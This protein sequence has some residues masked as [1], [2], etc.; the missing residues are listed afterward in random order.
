[1]TELPAPYEPIRG[2]HP[3]LDVYGSHPWVMPEGWRRYTENRIADV[4]ADAARTGLTAGARE[5]H[6]MYRRDAP[7]AAW[8]V[9]L[10]WRMLPSAAPIWAGTN[11]D[12]GLELAQPWLDPDNAEARVS[13]DSPRLYRWET[14]CWPLAFFR[15]TAFSGSPS[16]RVA[17][18]EQTREILAIY[19]EVPMLRQRGDALVTLF[20]HVRGDP[21]LLRRHERETPFAIERL[22]GELA[23]P[24]YRALLPELGG[25]V[26]DL[27]WAVEGFDAVHERVTAGADWIDADRVI[28]TIAVIDELGPLAGRS[29]IALALGTD[30]VARIERIRAELADGFERDAWWRES[31]AW[32]RENVLRGEIDAARVWAWLTWYVEAAIGRICGGTI[33]RLL[34][35][36]PEREALDLLAATPVAAPNRVVSWLSGLPAPGPRPEAAAEGD[37]EDE[38]IAPGAGFAPAAPVEI[39]D[40]MAELDALIGLDEVK[41]QV[42]LLVAEQ[43]AAELRREVG[44]DVAPRARHMVFTGSP[45]TAKTTVARLIARI[46]AQLGY[47]EKGHLVETS[48]AGLVAKWIGHTAI[49]TEETFRRALGGVL[50]ID[51]A[52]AL[53]PED[54]GRD[55]GPEAIST[56]LK[57]MEDHRDDVI[58]VVAGYPDE[59]RRFLDSNPGLASRF[60]T[61]IAFPGYDA[62]E[63]VRIFELQAGHAGFRLAPGVTD[64]VRALI[65][66]ERRRDFGNGR[67]VRNVFEAATATQALRITG[68]LTADGPDPTED[69]IRTLLPEDV[70]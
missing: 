51:E 63:L 14:L 64:R 30:R 34:Q 3:Y 28:A 70:G 48:R 17:A 22:W 32:R 54:P 27:A 33:R 44:M 7:A 55:T 50:F 60:P 59:M 46:F 57:L 24:D 1:M 13:A 42:A 36:H 10:A 6:P 18:L 12:L 21:G 61:H 29:E 37:G 11:P 26:G 25:P 45:G 66:A 9:W 4:M 16:W 65:P 23:G 62:D 31:S 41:E 38:P 2:L 35:T 67:W 8:P 5:M 20:D 58:V 47:L 56:L 19:R 15:H 53:A 40:P 52:Y 68:S 39:G 43:R 49:K 69:A